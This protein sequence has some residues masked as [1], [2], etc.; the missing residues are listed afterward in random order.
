M[1][2]DRLGERLEA[3]EETLDDRPDAGVLEEIHTI[4]RE[5]IYL[6]KQVWPLREMITHFS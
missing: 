4:R 2:L 1:I 5:L 6:R 3:L